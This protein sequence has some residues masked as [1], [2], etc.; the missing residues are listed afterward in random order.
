MP[1]W[2]PGLR[3]FVLLPAICCACLAVPHRSFAQEVTISA[4]VAPFGSSIDAAL[5]RSLNLPTRAAAGLQGEQ[6]AAWAQIDRDRL[7]ALLR[8]LGFYDANV[9][10][11]VDRR[12]AS[13]PDTAASRSGER[14]A[15][16]GALRI[17]F[18]PTA[19]PRYRI[20]S[21]RLVDARTGDTRDLAAEEGE[22]LA[23]LSGAPASADVLAGFEAEWLERERQ[24]GHVFAAVARRTVALDP[25]THSVDA[26][27][28]VIE[29]PQ[30]RFG[31][32][33]FSGLQRVNPQS[34][35]QYVPFKVGDPYAPAQLD[36]LRANLRSLPFFQSVRV[37]P[38]NALDASGLLPLQ[39]TVVEKPPDAQQLM[40]SGSIGIVVLALAAAMVAV[41][42][43]ATAAA[44]PALR[45]YR[46]TITA[47]IWILVA[48]S[49]LLALQRLLY[50]GDV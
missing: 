28:A 36:R 2:V 29:G 10:V 40:L 23:R 46:P 22:M 31:P 37:E 18:E 1:A 32:V 21:V 6:V 19:G 44:G 4:Q 43:L 50:L 9:H 25:G 3:T 30:A 13:P 20:R 41:A 7:S 35:D 26:T 24:A 15:D 16:A 47:A 8:A 39:A 17:T 45:R 42:E 27:I 38:A 12:A 11:A 14:S 48:T 49:A 5:H 33:Q 34:L